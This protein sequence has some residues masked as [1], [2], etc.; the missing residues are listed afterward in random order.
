MRTRIKIYK[1]I[2]IPTIFH[3]I[4]TWTRITK[5]DLEELESMQQKIVKGMCSLM[6]STPYYGLLSELGIWPVENLLHYKQITLYHNIITSK[7]GRLI[8]EIVKYQIENT[9]NGC[10]AYEVKKTCERY[11]IDI[12]IIKTLTKKV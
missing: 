9:W 6:K 8:S 7:E 12:D 1:C 4:E 10:W 3:N 2:I 11:K 5:G